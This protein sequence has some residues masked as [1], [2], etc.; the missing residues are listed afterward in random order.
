MFEI[1]LCKR[2]ITTKELE[3]I[4]F[5]VV[6][7]VETLAYNMA[8]GKKTPVRCRSQAAGIIL[9]GIRMK[10]TFFQS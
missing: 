2:T 9:N 6:Y 4:S 1:E 10:M 3:S 5:I 8:I 7:Y